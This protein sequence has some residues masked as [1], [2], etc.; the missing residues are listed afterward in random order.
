MAPIPPLLRAF[1][2]RCDLLVEL[3]FLV[4]LGSVGCT[5]SCNLERMFQ[6]S[7]VAKVGILTSWVEDVESSTYV[8]T[9]AL[10]GKSPVCPKVAGSNREPPR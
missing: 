1:L 2:G 9:K 3:L 6:E 5:L 4:P 10:W 8:H 7:D